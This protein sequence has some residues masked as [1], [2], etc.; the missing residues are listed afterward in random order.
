MAKSQ[1]RE[2]PYERAKALGLRVRS[3]IPEDVL[4]LMSLYRNPRALSNLWSTCPG[5]GLARRRGK[6]RR[7]CHSNRLNVLLNPLQARWKEQLF[8]RELSF[9]HSLLVFVTDRRL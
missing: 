4:K 9:D 2:T 6:R 8:S 5:R 1:K 7:R 3:D